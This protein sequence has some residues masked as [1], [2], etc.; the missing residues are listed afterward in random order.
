ML[1]STSPTLKHLWTSFPR[2]PAL[3]PVNAFD[4]AV[5]ALFDWVHK[6][7]SPAERWVDIELIEEQARWSEEEDDD[8]YPP[9]EET[10][11]RWYAQD[12]PAKEGKAEDERKDRWQYTA[13]D[14]TDDMPFLE[15]A[16]DAFELLVESGA[17]VPHTPRPSRWDSYK[18]V[19]PS[20]RPIPPGNFLAVT[21]GKT[22]PA[23]VSLH[24]RWEALGSPPA[25]P[26]KEW[27]GDLSKTFYRTSRFAMERT[28]GEALEDAAE[29]K[30]EILSRADEKKDGALKEEYA[31]S[32]ARWKL[33]D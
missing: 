15:A 17:D 22:T 31:A 11:A 6:D 32:Q 21:A 23:V 14:W 10:Y 24:E 26:W 2:H 7:G 5:L 16:E 12:G 18:P 25:D 27:E 30:P 9:E 1:R 29:E 13:A 33:E 19:L 28:P 3:P 4:P 8:E 20:L